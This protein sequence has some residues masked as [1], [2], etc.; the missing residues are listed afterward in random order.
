MTPYVHP[1]L[2]P[3]S[4]FNHQNLP[5]GRPACGMR[6]ARVGGDIMFNRLK[7]A[8][9]LLIGFGALLL[10]LVGISSLSAING[11]KSRDSL[12]E[13]AKY[14]SN[15]VL[16]HVVQENIQTGRMHMWMALGSGDHE[17]WKQSDEAFKLASD[18]LDELA[19]STTIPS[20]LAKVRQLIGLLQSFRDV[21][22]RFR[23][24]E[25][26]NEAL[27]T[28]EGKAVFA[29][30]LK[31]G[32]D[33][34]NLAA[35]L[36]QEY[37]SSAD[38]TESD[39]KESANLIVVLAVGA[40]LAS[41]LIGL[42][43]SFLIARSIR[44]P[45]VDLTRV[46]DSL[47]KG[48]LTVS[49]PNTSEPNEIGE[50]AR[51]VSVFKDNGVERLRLETEAA[52]NRAAA[53]AERERV[54][55]ERRQNEAEQASV[56]ATLADSLVKIAKGDLT[57]RIAADFKGRYQQIKTDFN[58]AVA[59]LD[60]TMQGVTGSTN[61]IHS[62]TQEISAA[63][64]DLSRR[65]E[66]QAASLEETAAALDEITATVKKSA[67]GATHAR[68]VV[69]AADGD[70]KKSAIVVRQAVEAMDAIAKS[71]QQISQIIGV[72]DEIAFQTNLLALNAGVEAARAGDAG[73]GFA[74][75]A[76]EVR[77]LAQRSAEA[78]KQIKG[79]ISAS[80]TQVDHGV[81]LVAETGKSLERIMAQVAEINDVVSEIAAGAKE[82]ATGLEEVNTA[83]NQMDQ[84]TQQNAAMV[85]E[86]TAAS[87]SLSQ[88][89]DQLSGLIGQFQVGRASA[90]DS[91]RRELEKV[92][93]HAFRQPAKAV[94]ANAPRTETRKAAARPAR[95]APK[96]MVANGSPVSADGDGWEEF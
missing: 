65:T 43:L 60:E 64:D 95:A 37:E 88:E 4:P 12:E 66:Q 45:I 38:Q 19:K 79:L 81:K 29:N 96:A 30:A 22:S 11:L 24:F 42:A 50:M 80:T 15:E 16:D 46:M 34:T 23:T 92:A 86:S 25:G 69:A 5:A 73:R 72:I 94:A 9:K 61:A 84:V 21:A 76:S 32:S 44:Q 75:V 55:A 91:I 49:V 26:Q 56:V 85:E 18:R 89:T 74:V 52:A 63:S 35:T 20:R 14:K 70:A 8:S 54:E 71:A 53:E 39:A 41:L 57:A 51:S 68:Q 36:S 82:Q 78:A 33:F 7:I 31:I 27:N 1:G 6:R 3:E 2:D 10:L 77:A 93:P 90:N 13:L 48:D 47:A 40:G 59:R 67:E 17:H 87:H 62:G 83:I 58:A 28:T